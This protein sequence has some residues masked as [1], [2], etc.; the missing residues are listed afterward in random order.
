MGASSNANLPEQNIIV[1]DAEFYAEAERVK[2]DADAVETILSKL[3]DE[4]KELSKHAIQ[5]GDTA[6]IFKEYAS[7]V[8]G[9]QGKL[10]ELVNEEHRLITEMISEIDSADG[11]I[12]GND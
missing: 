7:V 12:Y 9:M 11:F 10:L 6:E 5:K 2:N 3:S 4:L 8:S 1:A